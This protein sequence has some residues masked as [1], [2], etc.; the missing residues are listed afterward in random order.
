MITKNAY[1]RYKTLDNCFSNFG[2]MFFMK[3][4]VE[5]CNEVLIEQDYK[6]NGVQKRQIFNDIKFMESEAGWSVPLERN[7]IGKRIFYRYSDR[8][9]SINK[10]PLNRDEAENIKAAIEVISRF[11]GSPEFEWVNEVLPLLE[12]RFG[13]QNNLSKI[14]SFDDNFDYSGKKWISLIYKSIQNKQVLSIQYKDFKSNSAY[15]IVFHPYY[16]KQYNNR[17][18]AFGLN[19]ES[20]VQT[21]NLALDRIQSIEQDAKEYIESIID[22][23]EYFY[24]VV[25]VTRKE[26]EEVQE[27][28]LLFNNEIMPYIQT[29]PLHPSQKGKVVENGFEVRLKLILNYEFKSL[30]LSYG[31]KVK[32]LSPISLM[33]EIL[34]AR[35]T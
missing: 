2:K 14:I 8:N 19:E 13:L 23:E 25:G 20:Q 11:S 28:K 31:N 33:E 4:L 5:A 9:F 24:D 26:G 29:K 6:T 1:L 35:Y 21:W 30:L 16:L 27:I 22:W 34:D 15:N 12:S 17:W 3:D 18:F 10:Q 7:Y 32:V